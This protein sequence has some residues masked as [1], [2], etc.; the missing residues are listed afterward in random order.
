[1]SSMSLSRRSFLLS[2]AVLACRLG[3]GTPSRIP[4]GLEL[5]SVRDAFQ[6][7]PERTVRSIAQLGYECV[8]F[9]APYYECA[10]QADA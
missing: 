7:D 8:E 3:A 6:K 5:Y 4:I 2:S 1:M 9:Y 10:G